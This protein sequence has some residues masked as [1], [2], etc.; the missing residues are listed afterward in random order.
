MNMTLWAIAALALGICAAVL[1]GRWRR[2]V[3]RRAAA[4]LPVHDAAPAASKPR[5]HDLMT[6]SEGT[7][8]LLRDGKLIVPEG[9][10]DPAQ[11]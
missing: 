6:T 11:P 9:G 2:G 4:V 7:R 5:A 8:I 1:T 10:E 3:A